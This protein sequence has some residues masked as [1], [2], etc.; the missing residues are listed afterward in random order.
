MSG[1]SVYNWIKFPFLEIINAPAIVITSFRMVPCHTEHMKK[2]GSLKWYL[3]RGLGQVGLGRQHPGSWW[4]GAPQRGR[5][6][7]AGCICRPRWAIWSPGQ[8]VQVTPPLLQ[9][10]APYQ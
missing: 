4:R 8:W 3:L 2:R 1:S 5:R 10:R 9:P 7:G 6:G